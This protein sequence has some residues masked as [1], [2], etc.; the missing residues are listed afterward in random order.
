LEGRCDSN[1][2]SLRRAHILRVDVRLEAPGGG[3]YSRSYQVEA[4]AKDLGRWIPFG[5][6]GLW[7]TRAAVKISRPVEIDW[8][9]YISQIPLAL[10]RN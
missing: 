9:K 1:R 5:V 4:G 6:V 8:W 3:K 10:T 7:I 2:V